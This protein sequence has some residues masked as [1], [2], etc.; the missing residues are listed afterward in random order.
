MERDY[1]IGHPAASDYK[2]EKYTP[3]RAPFA[4][5]FP[6]DHPARLGKNVQALD[7]PDGSHARTVQE[8]K[9]NA[10][11]NAQGE[12]QP[13]PQHTEHETASVNAQTTTITIDG[14]V[15]TT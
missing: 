8:W 7:S 5:D 1:P 9:D 11:R 3:P 10:E 12:Q 2:G 15:E 6:P 4:E 14:T 13:A